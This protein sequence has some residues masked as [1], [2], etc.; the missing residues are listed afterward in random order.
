MGLGSS[1]WVHWAHCHP[2]GPRPC[3]GAGSLCPTE[4]VPGP[5]ALTLST[6]AS[7]AARGLVSVQRR[8]VV[9]DGRAEEEA[10]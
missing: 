3:G 8:V 4:P 9:V 2:L 1:S 5:G 6:L 7:E 10:G